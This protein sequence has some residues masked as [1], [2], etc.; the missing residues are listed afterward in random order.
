MIDGYR[1]SNYSETMAE[2]CPELESKKAGEPLRKAPA[3][4]AQYYNRRV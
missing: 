4:F 1:D 2:L 3:V